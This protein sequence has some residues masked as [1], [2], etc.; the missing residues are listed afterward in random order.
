MNAP[1]DDPV[2]ARAFERQVERNLETL[3]QAKKAVIE[4][5]SAMSRWLIASLLAI[6]SGGLFFVGSLK[7]PLSCVGVL[8]ASAFILGVL[9]AMLNAYLIQVFAMRALAPLESAIS[10]WTVIVAPRQENPE[11]LTELS[12]Q[13]ADA[14]RWAYTAPIAGWVSVL[15]FVVGV[16][17]AGSMLTQNARQH[18]VTEASK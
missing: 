8:S 2:F 11:R 4:E 17:A 7:F 12:N 10:Y 3:L 14:V 13:R 15:A 1:E 16:V 5:Q 9:A 6:N 18:P